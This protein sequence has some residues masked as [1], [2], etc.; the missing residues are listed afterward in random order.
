[1]STGG[2]RRARILLFVVPALWSTNY[3]IARLSDGVIAPHLLALGRWCLA[4]ALLLPFTW[5]ALVEHRAALKREW[6][7][8][9]VLGLLGMYI[10]GAWVY[11]AG[12]TTTSTNIALIYAVTPVSIAACSAW[13]LHEPLSGLQR[14]GIA[15]ALAGTLFVITRGDPAM[16]LH[17]QL[18][19]GDLWI[20]AAA[21]SWTAY[22]ILL[23]RW[24]S[25]LP[26]TPRLVAIIG[27]GLVALLPGALIEAMVDT[28]PAPGLKAV[29]LVVFAAVV[30]GVLSYGAYSYLQTRLGAARTALMLYLAPVYGAFGAW[31]LLGERPGLHH[32]IGA[33][34]ILPSIWLATRR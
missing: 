7:H 2:A 33:L 28:T 22:S 20:T 32:A 4:A 6:R 19:P 15:L 13:L 26:P 25:V 27:G 9:L 10:C 24:P 17:L 31:A 12:R 23:R 5:R 8:L 1:M 29:G 3:L 34:L 18:T 30:P 21:I 16:L 11:Q 14:V